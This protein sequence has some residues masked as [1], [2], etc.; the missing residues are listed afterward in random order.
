MPDPISEGQVPGNGAGTRGVC[1][2]VG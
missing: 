2:S 1:W